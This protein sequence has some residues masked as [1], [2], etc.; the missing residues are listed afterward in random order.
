[1]EPP[2]SDLSGSEALRLRRTLVNMPLQMLY[3]L[4]NKYEVEIPT[5][6]LDIYTIV[7]SFMDE[8]SYEAKREILSQYGDAGK[9]SSFVFITKEKTPPIQTIFAKAKTLL[10]IKPESMFWESYPYYDEVEIDH[11]TRTLRIRFHYLLGLISLIDETTGRPKEHR[12]YWR[13]VIVYRPNSKILEVRTKHRSMA[14]KMSARIPAYLGLEPFYSLNLMDEKM[15]RKFVEWISSLNSA[16]IELPISEVS[17]SLIITA[18]KGMDLRTAKR[19][20]EELRYG[21]LRH[22]HVTIQTDNNH[23]INFHI[24]FRNCHIKYTLFASEA[25]IEY[26]INALEKIS[27]GYIF[28]RPERMLIEYF[29]K[30]T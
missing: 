25:D 20:Q 8:L 7:D 1:M 6:A 3:S 9:V 29:E 16:T 12:Q 17:G 19:Y 27:E 4:A 13:G 11:A 14:T 26:V 23:K 22:G 10:N 21:R 30:K 18:R 5:E 15:N 24:Y 28:A 2:D